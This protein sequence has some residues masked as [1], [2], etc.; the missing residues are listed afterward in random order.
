MS[1]FL[2]L[3]ETQGPSTRVRFQHA[4]SRGQDAPTPREMQ[5]CGKLY[6]QNNSKY[7]VREMQDQTSKWTKTKTQT[8]NKTK[9][10]KAY[11]S[12]LI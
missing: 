9:K 11:V 1:T 12:G 2:Y 10:A 3:S 7:L 8:Q 6:W 4:M 5:G